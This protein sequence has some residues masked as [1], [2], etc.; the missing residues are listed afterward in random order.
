MATFLHTSTGGISLSGGAS[1]TSGPFTIDFDGPIGSGDDFFYWY[2][3]ESKCLSRQARADLGLTIDGPI[4]LD[5][6]TE[7]CNASYKLYILAKNVNDLARKIKEEKGQ[8]FPVTRVSRFEPPA[9]P[10]SKLSLAQRSERVRLVDETTEFLEAPEAL[11]FTI[12]VEVGFEAESD[13]DNPETITSSG[14]ASGIEMGGAATV[15]VVAWDASEYIVSTSGGITLGGS[16]TGSSAYYTTT[17]SGGVTFGGS[18]T[19]ATTSGVFASGGGGPVIGSPAED[20]NSEVFDPDAAIKV[21]SGTPILLPTAKISTCCENNTLPP[22]LV[23][24][25]FKLD[26]AGSIAKFLSRNGYQ[27]TDSTR[28][29]YFANRKMWQGTRMFQGQGFYSNDS[30]ILRLAFE[31]GCSQPP[32]GPMDIGSGKWVF[33]MTASFQN[34]R[35]GKVRSTR[36]LVQFSSQDVCID[37]IPTSFNFSV[38]TATKLATPSALQPLVLQDGASVFTGSAVDEQPTFNFLIRNA[39]RAQSSGEIYPELF[40]PMRMP[41][42]GARPEPTSTRVP[43][44][45]S[46]TQP[47]NIGPTPLL[48]S[49][50]QSIPATGPTPLSSLSIGQRQLPV[51]VIPRTPS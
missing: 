9:S 13:Q 41:V 38:N 6:E 45:I 27:L 18:A 11:E 10:L 3:V 26:R 50:D 51:V 39:N 2:R 28:I 43:T 15:S 40:R 35:T 32:F 46:K 47:S 20:D 12:D 29:T 21:V 49:D 33:G 23:V 4:P 1:D 14:L 34:L 17:S 8:I 48:A 30:E 31:F 42:R 36:M 16:A 44:L 24:Q 7:A 5:D 19:V 37:G 22:L 25:H